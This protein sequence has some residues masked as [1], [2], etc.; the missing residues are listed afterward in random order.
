[1]SPVS[2]LAWSWLLHLF[3]VSAVN[4]M[5]S[6]CPALQHVEILEGHNP[7]SV[8]FSFMFLFSFML[9]AAYTVYILFDAMWRG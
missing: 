9:S 5:A 8:L 2:S 7:A 3:L 6:W 4:T 1:M